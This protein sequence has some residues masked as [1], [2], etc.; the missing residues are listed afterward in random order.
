MVK[1]SFLARN[2]HVANAKMQQMS[3]EIAAFAKR[4]GMPGFKWSGNKGADIDWYAVG[5]Q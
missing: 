4:S 1:E 5:K 3:V 2:Q